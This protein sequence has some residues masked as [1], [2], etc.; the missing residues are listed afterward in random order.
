MELKKINEWWVIWIKNRS[1]LVIDKSL[2]MALL[3]ALKM[4]KK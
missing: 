1:Q 2:E 3:R 4:I